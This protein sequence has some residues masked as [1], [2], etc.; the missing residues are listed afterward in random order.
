MDNRGFEEAVSLHK[1]RVHSFATMMLKDTAEAQDVAQEALVRLWQHRGSVDEPGARSWLMRTAHNLCIDRIRKRRVR[2]EIADGET[3]VDLQ[4]DHNP[5][6]Q[7]RAE[8]S[9]IGDR[10]E[11]A[12]AALSGL[13]RAVI[14]MREVQGLPYD[15]IAQALGVPL[16][17][18]KARLHRARERLRAQLCRVGVTP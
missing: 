5:G 18:L 9:E 15:E 7:Q 16:G 3:V 12:L 13:D 11:G 2:S 14:V 4:S 6:P 1:D 17:T 10:I 8:A